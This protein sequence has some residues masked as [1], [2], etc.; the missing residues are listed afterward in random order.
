MCQTWFAME[1]RDG[2]VNGLLIDAN[3]T[4][5]VYYVWRTSVFFFGIIKALCQTAVDQVRWGT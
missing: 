4:Q 3:T 2:R 5:G 1:A